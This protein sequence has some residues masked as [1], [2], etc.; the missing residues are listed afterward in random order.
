MDQKHPT[1]RRSAPVRDREGEALQRRLDNLL[2]EEGVEPGD[3]RSYSD[4]ALALATAVLQPTSRSAFKQLFGGRLDGRLTERGAPDM[5]ANAEPKAAKKAR[6]QG[7]NGRQSK[8]RFA[9]GNKFGQGRPRRA[10]EREYL[11]VLSDVVPLDAWRKVVER[12]LQ[13]AQAGDDK[14]RVW[15]AKYLLDG[16]GN[17]LFQLAVREEQGETTDQRVRRAAKKNNI[18][19]S[20]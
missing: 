7:T 9:A 11:A 1:P 2:E 13:D 15:L 4:E 18:F 16:I 5:I 10:V 20:N 17:P 14:A 6:Q 3:L 12:A 8:G 19:D